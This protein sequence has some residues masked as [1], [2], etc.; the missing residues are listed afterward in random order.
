M[1]NCIDIKEIQTYSN[2]DFL[3][4]Y[5]HLS[6]ITTLVVYKVIKMSDLI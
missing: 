4:V 2:D 3:S 5:L 1:M 6:N